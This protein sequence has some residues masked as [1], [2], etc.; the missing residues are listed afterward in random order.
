MI[1]GVRP[2]TGA[3]RWFEI[4]S[5]VHQKLLNSLTADQLKGL[6]KDSMRGQIG[7]VVERLILDEAVPMTMAEREK[8]I[9]EILDDD[10]RSGIGVLDTHSVTDEHHVN[11]CVRFRRSRGDDDTFACGQA[12]G[13]DHDGR[14]ALFDV[15]V[16]KSGVCERLMCSGRNTMPLHESFSEILRALELCSTLRWTEYFEPRRI[17]GVHHASSERRFRTN[18]GQRDFFGFRKFNEFG[19]I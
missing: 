13:L 12:I 19:V 17:E 4:K 1:R 11:R 10:T 3:D 18:N 5:Q 7:A 14:A 15:R 16:R 8:V 6:N 9:E 2:S